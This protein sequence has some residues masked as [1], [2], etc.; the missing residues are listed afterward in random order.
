[1]NKSLLTSVFLML[2]YLGS[3]QTFSL[4]DVDNCQVLPSVFNENSTY[5]TTS[6]NPI[7]TD[8]ST[9]VS[10]ISPTSLTQA[11]VYLKLPKNVLAGS[12][13]EWAMRFYSEIPGSSGV[14]AGSL[15]IQIISQDGTSFFTLGNYDKTGGVWQSVGG[16]V[17]LPE[18]ASVNANGGYDRFRI[19]STLSAVDLEP[20]YFD[21][22]EA[23]I[24]PNLTDDN[25]DLLTNNGWIYN[26]R[27][28]DQKLTDT[29]NFNAIPTYEELNPSTVGNSASTAIQVFRTSTGGGFSTIAFPFPNGPLSP[30]FTGTASFR[31]YVA[32]CQL[33]YV[34]QVRINIRNNNNGTTQYTTNQPFT[35]PAN[36]WTEVTYDLASLTPPS[37]TPDS[38]YNEFRIIFDQG[39]AAEASGTL[40]YLDALQAPD[41]VL[42]SDDSFDTSEVKIFMP[43]QN[44]IRVTGIESGKTQLA[45]YDLLGKQVLNTSFEAN[46]FNDISIPSFA[47]GVYIAKVSLGNTVTS[48][49]IVIN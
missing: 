27:P 45:V 47:K 24:N 37:G 16:S 5:T 33:P 36:R 4:H 43:S 1:M 38:F 46:G 10:R 3:A 48:K 28:G 25:A 40:Y 31:I 14:E 9:D 8:S 29:S 13:F 44:N 6:P 7:N 2:F 11:G 30:P 34:N 35:I 15:R 18:S 23:N 22:I 32:T 19:I 17:L 12:T 49:K 39:F 21:N 26:N 42:L 41:A 20:L